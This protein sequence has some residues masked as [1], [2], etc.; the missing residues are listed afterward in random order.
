MRGDNF[1]DKLPDEFKP[2]LVHSEPLAEEDFKRGW[3]KITRFDGCNFTSHYV[4]IDITPKRDSS[5]VAR[6]LQ[7]LG[8]R[9]MFFGMWM[10]GYSYDIVFTGTYAEKK[11]D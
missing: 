1:W 6:V 3:E 5:L 11:D 4:E 7:W 10:G 2:Y 8:W 9:L